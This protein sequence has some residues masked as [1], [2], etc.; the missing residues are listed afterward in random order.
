[1]NTKP[2][3]LKPLVTMLA[4][5]VVSLENDGN[6]FALDMI[7]RVKFV[8]FYLCSCFLYCKLNGS[9]LLSS[10]Y[11]AA[12]RNVASPNK[13]TVKDIVW[14]ITFE[15]RTLRIGVLN[16]FTLTSIHFATAQVMDNIVERFVQQYVNDQAFKQVVRELVD[17]HV[18]V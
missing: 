2:Q 9:L 13:K 4:A 8:S 6:H 11:M 12:A 17:K 16:V 14:S 18:Q 5:A 15:V 3:A 1:M 7:P 10:Q